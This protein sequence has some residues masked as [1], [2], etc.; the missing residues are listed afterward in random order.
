MQFT[1]RVT[2]RAIAAGNGTGYDRAA[3]DLI[4]EASKLGARL[5]I[6]WAPFHSQVSAGAHLQPGMGTGSLAQQL[7]AF[8]V[9]DRS[10]LATAKPQKCSLA[11]ADCP[12]IVPY[13]ECQPSSGA[14]DGFDLVN[15]SPRRGR[16]QL[17]C[18]LRLPSN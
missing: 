9:S 11:A 6:N 18:E 16:R 13:A 12:H 1:L 5:R 17:A 7:S 8:R 14:S 15:S 4:D 10:Q 2:Q 3:S